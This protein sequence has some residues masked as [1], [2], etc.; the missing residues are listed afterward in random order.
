MKFNIVS[1]INNYKEAFDPTLLDNKEYLFVVISSLLNKHWD[2]RINNGKQKI[3]SMEKYKCFDNIDT[4][5]VIMHKTITHDTN[6]SDLIFMNKI[7]DLNNEVRDKSKHVK[8]SF[9]DVYNYYKN[10]RGLNSKSCGHYSKY[11]LF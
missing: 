1:P 8:D 11:D 3:D 5:L 7:M 6:R 10:T 4:D 9:R 2:F